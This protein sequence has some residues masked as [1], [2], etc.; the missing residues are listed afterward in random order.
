MQGKIKIWVLDDDLEDSEEIER[1]FIE[2]GIEEYEMFDQSEKLFARMKDHI[3]ILVV[4]F[5]LKLE[6]PGVNGGTVVEKT[7]ECCPDCY[8]IVIS[9][10]DS[11]K[12]FIQLLN[13]GADWYIDKEGPM[14]AES[15]AD[16]VLVGQRKVQIALDKARREKEREEEADKIRAELMQYREEITD[17]L[18]KK[19]EAH[20]VK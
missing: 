7:R 14:W 17:R 6:L 4:D 2:R 1:V 10:Q 5:V 19:D 11:K 12:N 8:I 16:A 9:G 13:M 20:E 18:R 15:L 3:D